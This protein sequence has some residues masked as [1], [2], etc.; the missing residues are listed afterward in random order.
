[1]DCFC[2]YATF[3]CN[4]FTCTLF[5]QHYPSEWTHYSLRTLSRILRFSQT[6]CLSLFTKVLRTTKYGVWWTE[7][8]A[9][10]HMRHSTANLMPCLEKTVKIPVATSFIFTGESL[11]WDWSLHICPKLTVHMVSHW[12]LLILSYS[13]FLQSS[14]TFSMWPALFQLFILLVV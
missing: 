11:G 2:H 9:T 14:D 1:M 6:T 5:S 13:V 8:N 10:Q 7:V 3:S 4:K 12:I